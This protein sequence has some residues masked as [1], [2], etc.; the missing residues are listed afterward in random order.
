M[1]RIVVQRGEQAPLIY[2]LVAD[3]ETAHTHVPAVRT[4]CVP[5]TCSA[6]GYT[7]E[8]Q[9]CSVCDL[10][11]GSTQTALPL[12]AHTEGEAQVETA[13]TCR[14]EGSAAYRCTE[15]GAVL[16]TEPLPTVPHQI[17]KGR[18][19]FCGKYRFVIELQKYLEKVL[20]W[21]Q[22]LRHLFF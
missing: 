10:L 15:C 8:T 1:I 4:D 19:I 2:T 6:A 21:F 22:A 17:E 11:L 14:Q 9:Y 16:R 12:A 3:S 18:C 7:I 20:A 5:S 13:P